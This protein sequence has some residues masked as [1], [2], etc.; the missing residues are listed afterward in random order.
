MS[1]GKIITLICVG[2]RHQ[3]ATI[4]FG[5]FVTNTGQKKLFSESV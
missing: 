2:G 5:G 4:S 3:S 1:Y